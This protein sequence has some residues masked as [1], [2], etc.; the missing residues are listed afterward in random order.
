MLLRLIPALLFASAGWA[1]IVSDVGA[2]MAQGNFRLGDALVARYRTQYGVTPEMIE[3]VSWLSRGALATRQLDL[4]EAYAKQTEALVGEQLK[5][6]LLDSDPHLP[7]ALGAAIEVRGLALNARGQRSDAIAYLQTELAVYRATSIRTRIQK[8]INL[9]SLEGKLAPA[10]EEREFLG[11]K[12]APLAS[13]KGK[14]VLLFFWAHWC[15][16]CKQEGPILAQVR[17]EYASKGL[18]FIA[19]T[20]HYGYVARGEEAG[21]AAELKYIDQVR[22]EF[23]GDLIDAPAPVSEQNFKT[24]GASSTPTLVLIDRRG[25]VRVYHPGTMTLEELRSALNRIG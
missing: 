12:P 25:I 19:P 5:K 7:V 15:G 16:D 3:A 14:P 6:H 18:V 10:L 1:G 11:S 13:L 9:L 4:A 23:Y 20:Q 24:Y 8:N 21:P 17:K 2:A 22:H